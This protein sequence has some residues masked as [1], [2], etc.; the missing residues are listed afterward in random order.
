MSATLFPAESVP[1]PNT[2]LGVDVYHVTVPFEFDLLLIYAYD[3]HS[4][5]VFPLSVY[6][7]NAMIYGILNQELQ[8]QLGV[9]VFLVKDI[10]IKISEKA[11]SIH[12]VT[13]EMKAGKFH[14]DLNS[15]SL[16]SAFP[17]ETVS[18]S[19]PFDGFTITITARSGYLAHTVGHI[20]GYKSVHGDG[21]NTDFTMTIYKP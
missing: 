7:D 11:G 15:K 21:F 8:A 13:S 5:Q 3:L 12:K 19:N 1:I 2:V 17:G 4:Q 18:L 20:T 14:A 6:V 10:K 16:E 9:P